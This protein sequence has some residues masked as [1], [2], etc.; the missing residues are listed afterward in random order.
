[1]GMKRNPQQ[2]QVTCPHRLFQLLLNQKD[3]PKKWASE[4]QESTSK[5]SARDT[6]Q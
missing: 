1:M 6:C 3:R 2:H 5:P 4:Q